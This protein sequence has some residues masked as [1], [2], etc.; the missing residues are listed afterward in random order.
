MYAWT[1]KKERPS[2]PLS[3]PPPARRN[4]TDTELIRNGYVCVHRNAVL[5]GTLP[6]NHWKNVIFT[7]LLKK[8]VN[9]VM[10]KNSVHHLEIIKKLHILSEPPFKFA[11]SRAPNCPK[12]LQY[13]SCNCSSNANSS[14]FPKLASYLCNCSLFWYLMVFSTSFSTPVAEN[15]A[16]SKQYFQGPVDRVRSCVHSV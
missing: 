8:K 1:L 7:I 2:S 16:P 14:P 4:G 15:H 3:F 11:E 5:N 12:V 6:S 10:L 9:V 13:K